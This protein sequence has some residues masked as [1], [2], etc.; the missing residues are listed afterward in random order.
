MD[1]K[2]LTQGHLKVLMEQVEKLN[3]DISTINSAK[4]VV[5]ETSHYFDHLVTLSG[6]KMLVQIYN[7]LNEYESINDALLRN[8]AKPD[9]PNIIRF[10]NTLKNWNHKKFATEL[11]NGSHRSGFQNWS[12]YFETT[13]DLDIF[14]N[15]NDEELLTVTFKYHGIPYA[16]VPFT[17]ESLWESNAMWAEIIYHFDLACKLDT[18]ARAVEGNEMDRKY[19]QYLYNPELFVYSVAAHLISS[20]FKLGDI[21]RIFCLSK[22][23]SS[24][25]L[26]LPFRF[27]REIK[28]TN[29]TVFNGLVN[30]LIETA[31][32][33]NPTFIFLALLENIVESGFDINDLC[34][35]HGFDVNKILAINNLPERLVLNEEILREMNELSLQVAGPHTEL[36]SFHKNLGL[37]YFD[38]FG[39]EGGLNQHP[40]FLIALANNSQSCVFQG[41]DEETVE[42]EESEAYKRQNL[43]EKVFNCMTT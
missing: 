19:E 31:N 34:S 24:I 40:A 16:R 11:Y 41:W 10:L 15:P 13:T 21:P 32:N 26:N 23:L 3:F 35:E 25:S 36:Y 9:A 30:R 12:Y 1:F 43:F 2:N 5:H 20:F 42:E 29:G 17:I 8:E 18:G 39:I 6:Q 33:L 14:N 7:A 4:L 37:K 22:A 38:I 28:K 27:Y